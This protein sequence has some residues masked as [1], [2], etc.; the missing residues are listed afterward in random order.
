MNAP[1]VNADGE[2]WIYSWHDL[3]VSIGFELLHERSDGLHGELWVAGDANR[4]G[5][6]GHISW[7]TFNL[8]S[9]TARGRQ[10][11]ILASRSNGQHV[12]A[13]TWVELLEYACTRTAQE[14]RRGEPPV[15]LSEGEP[16]LE[17]P[18]LVKPFLAEGQPTVLF[19]DGQVGKGWI[20]LALCLS[21]RL[22][23][24]VLPGLVPTRQCNCLYLDWETD[25]D[26]NKRRLAYIYRGL[27]L[28][29]RPPGISYQ[30][31]YRPLS[32]EASKVRALIRQTQSELM[33]IDSIGLAAAGDIRESD[34]ATRFMSTVRSLG[35]TSL[36]IGHVSKA[37]ATQ[38]GNDAGRVIGSTFYQLL[39]RSA[40]EVKADSETK[41]A[42]VGFYH[43]KVNLGPMQPSFALRMAFQDAP[44]YQ[45]QFSKADLEESA[46][47]ADRAPIPQRMV[48]ALRRGPLSNSDLAERLGVN[49]AAL[50]KTGDR[51]SL[52]GSIVKLTPKDGQGK[53]SN[54]PVWGLAAF[55]DGREA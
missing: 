5:L 26:S 43:R 13:G 30:R 33:V 42:I 37:V 51:L 10:A 24:E 22:G 32:D 18:Y 11:T 54:E 52:R 14:S 4:N 38:K 12:K 19:G 2:S 40:W 29:A 15:D 46:L 41:P 48:A 3:G 36:L 16:I 35:I 21:L 7:G 23:G 47:I 39:A 31:L 20:A 1:E 34:P 55:P 6:D 45:V 25:S 17:L 53:R 49:P 44:A 27:G 50:R 28:H 9:P 8:S